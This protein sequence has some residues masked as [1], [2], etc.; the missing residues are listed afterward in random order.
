MEECGKV[1]EILDMYEGAS[2]QKVNRS[3]TALFF[4]KHTLIEIKHDIKVA[5]GVLETMQYKRYLGLPFFVGK[6]KKAN[7]SYIKERVWRKLQRWEG[8]LLS[9]AG[10]EVSL[11]FV[12]Q[13][14]LIYTMGCF[15]IPIG[16]CNEIESLMKKFW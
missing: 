13:A 1:L 12:I 7:F 11:K 4:S 10:R 8:R 9:Q 5:L 6:R 3:K 14:I 2:G 15:T 16:L